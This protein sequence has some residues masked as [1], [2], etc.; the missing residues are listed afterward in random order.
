[1][2]SIV[3]TLERKGLSYTSICDNV[4]IDEP[5]SIK[6][7]IP[8]VLVIGTCTIL[9]IIITIYWACLETR[10]ALIKELRDVPA[11]ELHSALEQLYVEHFGN[12]GPAVTGVERFPSA[13]VGAGPDVGRRTITIVEDFGW[14]FPY[15]QTDEVG[16]ERGMAAD[17]ANV[18]EMREVQSH[19]G[20]H[21]GDSELPDEPSPYAPR[22]GEVEPSPAPC[23]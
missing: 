4:I 12:A 11:Y 22:S 23:P 14:G 10:K 3:S 5:S 13:S 20:I 21:R 7:H 15:P 16:E 19:D 17:V 18:H 6:N 2:F 8:Y 1:M 9:L